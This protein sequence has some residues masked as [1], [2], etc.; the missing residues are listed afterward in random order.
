MNFMKNGINK[1]LIL[2]R[3]DTVKSHFEA[4]A[5]EFDKIILKLI[6]QIMKIKNIAME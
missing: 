5:E 2:D 1:G 4:E 3:I 6:P